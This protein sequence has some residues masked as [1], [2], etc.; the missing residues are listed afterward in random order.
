MIGL[1]FYM[2]EGIG[3][4]L[5]IMEASDEETKSIFSSLIFAALAML[6][7]INI[8]FS[9]L[10]YYAY[11][12]EITEPIFIQQMPE[13]NP[14]I[15]TAKILYVIMV[16][17]SY[18]LTIYITNYVIEEIVFSKM[19]YSE[20]RKWLKNL[21]RTIVVALALFISIVFYYSLHKILGFS[22]LI[23]GSIVVLIVPS[24]IHN[25]LVATTKTE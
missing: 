22:G 17:I 3:T 10:C 4:I 25:T 15:I 8:V 11:G 20:L 24:L 18:P 5:P 14:A 7:L 23:L 12:S 2:F 19:E 21:S 6:A 1:S 9:E 13:E 16:V